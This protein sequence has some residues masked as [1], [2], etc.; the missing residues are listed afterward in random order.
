MEIDGGISAGMVR[1]ETIEV[2][3]GY[4]NVPFGYRLRTDRVP[5]RYRLGTDWVPVGYRLGTEIL[6]KRPV[7]L[8]FFLQIG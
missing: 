1:Y 2:P 3:F 8:L 5:I 7:I 4:R 6:G